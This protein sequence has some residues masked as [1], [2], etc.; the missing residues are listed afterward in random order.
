MPIYA[1]TYDLNKEK[2]YQILWDEFRRLD[3][4]KAARSFYLINVDTDD[5]ET[6]KEHFRGFVDKDDTLIVVK[7][8]I[9]EIS[10]HR[11]IEGTYRWLKE[12]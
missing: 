3:G 2:N 9:D 1:I 4:R 5:T 6:V 8:E 10:A 12:N 7:T 11:P